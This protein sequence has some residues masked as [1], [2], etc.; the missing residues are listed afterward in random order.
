MIDFSL[1]Y[2]RNYYKVPAYKDQRV[3]VTLNGATRQGV[4]V[5]GKNAYIQI[6][7]DGDKS[8]YKGCFHPTDG[9]KYLT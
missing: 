7:F 3:E 6:K 4:I 8:M 2:I 5:K 1:E 9:V